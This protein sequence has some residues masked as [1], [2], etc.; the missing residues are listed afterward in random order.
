MLQPQSTRELTF[1]GGHDLETSGPAETRAGSWLWCF[2]VRTAKRGP[3]RQ[4]VASVLAESQA[5]EGPGPCTGLE[6][7]GNQAEPATRGGRGLL[8]ECMED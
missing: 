1:R 6:G 7:L 3:R 2:R 5:A 4:S 8:N